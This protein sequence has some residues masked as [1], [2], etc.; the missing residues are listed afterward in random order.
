[1]NLLFLTI[2]LMISSTYA[3]QCIVNPL[4]EN[5]TL[6]VCTMKDSP[7][8]FLE[9][10]VVS[11]HFIVILFGISKLLANILEYFSLLPEKPLDTFWA[12]WWI[13]YSF[14]IN[15]SSEVFDIVVNSILIGFWLSLTSI[16]FKLI[17]NPRNSNEMFF[18]CYL[19]FMLI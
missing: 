2:F 10:F 19:C 11:M 6:P 7:T 8:S 9:N 12:F 18:Y 1:M 14:N 17:I 13:Y 3:K 15:F 16:L 4:S 5:K